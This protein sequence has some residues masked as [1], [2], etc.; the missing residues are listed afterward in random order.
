MTGIGFLICGAVEATDGTNRLASFKPLAL[1]AATTLKKS[2]E[3]TLGDKIEPP[4]VQREIWE[5]KLADGQFALVVRVCGRPGYPVCVTQKTHAD[6]TISCAFYGR[7]AGKKKPM[8]PAEA[9][10]R[11][12]RIHNEDERRAR[13]RIQRRLLLLLAALAVVIVVLAV[14]FVNI[15]ATL[16]PRTLDPDALARV[17][18][19]FRGSSVILYCESTDPEPHEVVAMLNRGFKGG[20]WDA[21]CPPGT[22]LGGATH[23]T[24]VIVSPSADERVLKAANA[25]AVFLNTQSLGPVHVE[26]RP[27]WLDGSA[28]A[29]FRATLWVSVGAK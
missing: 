27:N 4:L 7:E 1:E 10:A 22:N 24:T 26:A 17:V 13:S 9:A 23:G 25:V 19:P 28:P 3:D 21:S 5:V 6:G 14:V 11:R 20:G 29:C 18:A 8:S 12:D 2:M 15:R 16:A